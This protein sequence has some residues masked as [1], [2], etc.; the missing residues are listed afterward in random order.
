MTV[1][2]MADAQSN[3]SDLVERA[4]AGEEIIVSQAGTPIVRLVAVGTT[5]T[6]REFGWMAGIIHIDEGF[7]DPLPAEIVSGFMGDA[8]RRAE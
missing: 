3:L 6:R 1:V 2:N 5:Q 4:A 8:S 7:N